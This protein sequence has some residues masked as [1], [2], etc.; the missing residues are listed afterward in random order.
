MKQQKMLQ[1][2]KDPQRIAIRNEDTM[3]FAATKPREVKNSRNF[4]K[5]T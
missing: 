5:D 2:E 3:G 1:S 4:V